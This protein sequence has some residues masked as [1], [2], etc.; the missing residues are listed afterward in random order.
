MSFG[1]DEEI[2]QDFLVEAGEILEQLSEQLVELESRPDDADLL[3]AIFRGFHTVKGGA[4]FLQL[5]ELVECCHIAENVFDVLRKGERRVDAELMDVVLEALDA[6]NGMFAQVRERSE[7]TPATPELLAALARLAEP[8][9]AEAAPAPAVPVPVEPAPVQQAAQATEA[10]ITDSEFE[11]L[12][13]SLDAVK[14]QAAAEQMPAEPVSGQG[15]DI[16][17]AEF[18]SLLD[19]LHGKGQFSA[20]VTA[21]PVA[22]AAEP[23]SDEITDAEFESLLDQLHGKGTFQADALPAAKAAAPVEQT[24]AITG[25]DISEHEFEALLDQLHGKGKFNGDVAAVDAP[26]SVQAAAPARAEAPAV[27]RPAGAAAPVAAPKP[28]AAPRAPAA[29]A[30]KH[31]VSEA[32]TTVRV[33]TAR[34]DEIM[35]MV[36]ELVL[37][38]NRLVRLGLNSGDEAMSKAVSNLDVVTADLQTAVMKTRM[39]PIKKVFGRFPR[40][41]RDLARQLKKEINLELVG[42]ETDLDKNLVEALADPLVHLVRNAV[43]HGVEMPDEREAAGKARTGR[44]VLSAEQ[45]G[46]HILLSISDDGKGM[47]PNVLRAKAVEKGLMDKDAADRLSESDCYNLIFAPGFSTKTEISD[48]SGRGVGMDV[49]KTKISQLNGSINIYSAKGQ[50]SK[51][52]IKVPLTLAIMPTLMVM[53][54]NQAFAFPLVNVNEIFHLDLSR[55]NV[56]DGQEV[57]IV[58]D[59]ALPLF[60]LKRW[61]VQGQVHEEQHEGHVVILSVGTQR[62]GFVVDQLVGQEEVV[63]KPLGK[64]LQGTPG[65][66][67]ATITGDGRIALILDVPSMLKRY[68][69]RRI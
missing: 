29:S 8:G 22:A 68:A 39:Q 3:N 15:D 4:G 42:E 65:M 69:A 61:L 11:Q 6:V 23:A 52:V 27:A 48:V 41:V 54:G 16:T 25:D 38:R 9:S 67:G 51:I 10:D 36:G 18:E 55:T 31:A 17:D 7:V 30:D 37:V 26:A 19:Q 28:A 13:D 59:K 32:E 50:G 12:L 43:D 49:V 44:V 62:I 2:L 14:A 47:D 33:D 60:Y 64:M 35:N 5:N 46:D 40:L 24:S 1:A 57:V 45:E 66:S 21:Q 20:E 53:L 34:L 56:V 58:R 63:I